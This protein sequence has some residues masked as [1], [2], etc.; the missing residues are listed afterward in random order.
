MFPEDV[1]DATVGSD[2]ENDH[3]PGE[4]EVGAKIER[5]FDVD[6]VFVYVTSL[7]SPT[8]AVAPRIFKVIVN[9][10]DPK[11]PEAAWRAVIVVVPMFFGVKTFPTKVAIEV[12]SIEN[13]QAPGEL[14]VGSIKFKVETLSFAIVISVNVPRIFGKLVTVKDAVASPPSQFALADCV[15]VIVVVPASKNVRASPDTVAILVS[16]D[17]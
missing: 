3:A 1:I 4:L 5:V 13:V 17:L 9:V 6:A 11:P 12:F 10:D 2:E 7:K 15:A 14:E 16:E 8:A